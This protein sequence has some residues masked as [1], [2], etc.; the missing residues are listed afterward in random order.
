MITI[1]QALNEKIDLMLQ[2]AIT[3]FCTRF[4][5]EGQTYLLEKG[6]SK[7]LI[8]YL[9]TKIRELILETID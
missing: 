2:E 3:R 8:Q 6:V 5:R 7:G 9:T 4:G 1:E